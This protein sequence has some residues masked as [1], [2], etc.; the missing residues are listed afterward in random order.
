MMHLNKYLTLILLYFVINLHSIPILQS[1]D[2]VQTTSVYNPEQNEGLE[3]GDMVPQPFQKSLTDRGVAIKPASSNRWAGGVVPYEFA[4]NITANN[5]A[6]IV[7][8]MRAMENLT[9]VNNTQCISFRPRNA[10]DLYFITIF[11]GSG[12]YSPVGSWGS[13]IGTRP[14]SLMHGTYSTCMVSGIVQ[15]ELTHVLGFYH[16]QSRPDRDSYVSIQWANIDPSQAFNFVKYNDSQVD[17]EMT[18]YDYGSVMHYEWNAFALNSSGPTIIP[19][20][21]TSAYIGQRI[22]LSPVDILAIQRYYGCVPT[23]NITT[24]TTS[25]TITTTLMSSTTRTTIISST[26]NSSTVMSTTTT[27]ATSNALKIGLAVGITVLV[28]L[29]IVGAIIAC[30]VIRKCRT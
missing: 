11:N 7:A 13:Y 4:S 27:A 23:P 26:G 2:T 15:H 19:T 25:T 28:I 24:T 21:N 10:S 12:C 9:Q 8:Q 14:V 16:E 22:R 30:I 17:V 1:S 6:F 3:G 18:S 29:I 5:S 20:Q